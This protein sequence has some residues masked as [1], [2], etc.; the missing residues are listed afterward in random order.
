M[1]MNVCLG[2]VTAINS[3]LIP[4]EATYVVATLAIYWV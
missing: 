4:L 1:T 3:V 2:Q